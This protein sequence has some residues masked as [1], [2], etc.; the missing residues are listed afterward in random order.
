MILDGV[1]IPSNTPIAS[2]RGL[3][4]NSETIRLADTYLNHLLA[5]VVCCRRVREIFAGQPMPYFGFG[6]VSPQDP[7]TLTGPQVQE[8]R[9]LFR[10]QRVHARDLESLA[11]AVQEKVFEIAVAANKGNLI[12]IFDAC[13]SSQ[14]EAAVKVAIWEIRVTPAEAEIGFLQSGDDL[15]NGL[16]VHM[17]SPPLASNGQTWINGLPIPAPE[18]QPLRLRSYGHEFDA[19]IS[20]LA[21]ERKFILAYLESI[22]TD[23]QPQGPPHSAPTLPV[24]SDSHSVPPSLTSSQNGDRRSEIVAIVSALV[25]SN[26]SFP[27][28]AKVAR[29]LGIPRTNLGRIIDGDEFLK[30][31]FE[32]RTIGS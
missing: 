19:L 23:R 12:H 15:M 32:S 13:V 14:I 1:Q 24:V 26:Q 9:R 8:L 31:L 11:A 22:A 7:H 18:Q 27:T 4:V 20:G 25:V 29:E 28:K 10:E 2:T 3:P 30:R 5:L 21:E 16:I 6:N 17:A